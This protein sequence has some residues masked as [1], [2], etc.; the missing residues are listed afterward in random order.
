MALPYTG[1]TGVRPVP[2]KI[3][4][5][6]ERAKGVDYIGIADSQLRILENQMSL[7]N[8]TTG[9]RTVRMGHA[10]IEAWKCNDLCG[11]RITTTGGDRVKKKGR[12]CFCGCS[13][14]GGRI[15]NRIDSP[16]CFSY[17]DFLQ[18]DVEVCKK[19]DRYILMQN[20]YASDLTLYQQ[21]EKVLLAWMPFSNGM[22]FDTR[23]NNNGCNITLSDEMESCLIVGR[24]HN[25]IKW[26]D[27]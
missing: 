24:R 27:Q 6:G 13:M 15:L 18:Y 2:K 21:D 11:V 22:A 8:R 17:L 25:L 14:A 16:C 10:V 20:I 7:G 19:S 4:I 26:V 5:I 3:E 23:S 1:Y 12:K 9:T